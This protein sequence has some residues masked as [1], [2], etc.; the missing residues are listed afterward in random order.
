M[1]PVSEGHN[2]KCNTSLYQ[3]QLYI[4]A[5]HNVNPALSQRQPPKF[6]RVK[7]GF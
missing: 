2:G 4:K 6:T 5:F 1:Q 3:C 7:S